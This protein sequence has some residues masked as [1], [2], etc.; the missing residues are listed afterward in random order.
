[1]DDGDPVGGDR[2]GIASRSAGRASPSGY[3]RCRSCPAPARCRAAR[4]RLPSLPSARRRS[5]RPSTRVAMPAEIIAAVFEP[6][7]PLDQLGGDRPLGDDADDAAHQPFSLRI[8]LVQAR[9][10]FGGAAWLVDLPGARDRQRIGRHVRRDDAAGRDIGAVADR[11]R[12][13]QRRVRADKR[14]LADC[15][16][17]LVN[18]VVIAGD[19]AGA[20][21]GAGAD[22]AVAEIGEVVGLDPGAEPGRLDLDEIADMH[23]FFEHRARAQPGERPDDRARRDRRRLRDARTSGCG[24][25]R[26]TLTPG[27]NT[28]LRLDDDIAPEPR[29]GRQEH[30]L[31]RDQGR[32]GFHRARAAA[33]PASALR[34]RPVRR[35]C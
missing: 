16:A 1:M 9:P 18:A 28:T 11:D 8:F 17:P 15:R 34:P 5:M 25:C 31:R 23:V 6:A 29:I 33:G 12:R 10:Q 21:I 14:A 22:I 4:P 27:P 24:H 30:G 26:P 32:A 19:R 2:M 7:Q 35:G 20:D 13:D 3:G